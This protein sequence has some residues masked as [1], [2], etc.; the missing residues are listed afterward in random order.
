[1]NSKDTEQRAPQNRPPATPRLGPGSDARLPERSPATGGDAQRLGAEPNGRRRGSEV[2]DAALRQDRQTRGGPRTRDGDFYERAPVAYLAIDPRGL[3]GQVNRA[4]SDLLGH[5]RGSLARQPLSA[6]IAPAD[7]DLYRA[8]RQRLLASNGPEGAEIRLCGPDGTLHWVQLQAMATR[9]RPGGTPGLRAILIDIE[10]LKRAEEALQESDRRNDE[11]LSM[12][13]H[14]LRNPLTPIRNAAF[15]LGQ[16][17]MDEARVRWVRDTVETQVAH[18]SRLMD[19]LLDAARMVRGKV[20]LHIEPVEM[21]EAVRRAIGKVRALMDLK[22]HRLDL[23]LPDG[24]VRVSGDPVRLVQML[25]NLLDNAAR[26]TQSGGHI[27]VRLECAGTTAEIQVQDDGPGIPMDLLPKVFDLFRQG[28]RGPDRAQG[29]LG[30]GLALVRELALLH[31]GDATAAS[32]GPGLGTTF[33]LRLPLAGEQDGSV[34]GEIRARTRNGPQAQV[35]LRILVVEDDPAVSE[36]TATLLRSEGHHVMT[37]DCGQRALDLMGRLRPNVVLLDIGL[38]GEDGY[39]VAERIREQ[40]GGGEPILVGLSGYSEGMGE[41]EGRA[42]RLDRYL[43]K[44]VEP[45]ALRALLLDLAGRAA[46]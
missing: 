9:K 43:V 33:V 7:M 26:F 18:L 6:F 25:I 28:P 2:Q 34:A 13:A 1:M 45:S 29:G 10:R 5:P 24:P 20:Q 16:P 19:D 38:P 42:S 32:P 14:E 21:T 4:A 39:R 30:L 36:S 11:F 15:V 23:H 44:P 12:L 8:L 41:P 3:I 22:R 46:G 37:A 27:Q 31:G 40:P 35:C 17:G